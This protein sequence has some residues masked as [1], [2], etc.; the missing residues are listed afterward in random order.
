[1]AVQR[2]EVVLFL[3]LFPYDAAD[4]PA[5]ARYQDALGWLCC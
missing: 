5:H 1:M 4:Q 3:K 2:D